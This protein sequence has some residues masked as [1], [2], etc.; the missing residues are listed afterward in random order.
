MWFAACELRN[1]GFLPYFF[2]N[3]NFLRFITPDYGDAY[4]NGHVY[5]RGAAS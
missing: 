3:E 5:P 1:P 2:V 4:G